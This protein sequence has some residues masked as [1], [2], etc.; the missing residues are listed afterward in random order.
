MYKEKQSQNNTEIKSIKTNELH[1]LNDSSLEVLV[2]G[3]RSV[4]AVLTLFP[5]VIVYAEVAGLYPHC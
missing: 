4:S 5:T 3:F 2:C 1:C